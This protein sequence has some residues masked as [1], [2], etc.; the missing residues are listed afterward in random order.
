MGISGPSFKRNFQVRS[1]ARTADVSLQKKPERTFGEKIDGYPLYLPLYETN[2]SGRR[3]GSA[4]PQCHHVLVYPRG[5]RD[6]RALWDTFAEVGIFEKIT[7][8]VPIMTAQIVGPG[9]Q[10]SRGGVLCVRR[11]VILSLFPVL[12]PRRSTEP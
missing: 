1:G 8:D 4:P 10:N 5:G 11:R 6:Q 12:Q 3:I 9:D 2:L 7:S